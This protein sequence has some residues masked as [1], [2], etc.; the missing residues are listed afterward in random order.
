ME[1]GGAD[2][3]SQVDMYTC[4]DACEHSNQ[5]MGTKVGSLR[6]K[7]SPTQRHPGFHITIQRG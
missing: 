4:T 5:G 1:R 3:G 2:M 7:H 6:H